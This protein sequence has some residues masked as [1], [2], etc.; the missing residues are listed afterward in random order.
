M[1][2]VS[3]SRPMRVLTLVLALVSIFG[4]M[5]QMVWPRSS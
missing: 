1:K 5:M 2:S 3:R 4:L